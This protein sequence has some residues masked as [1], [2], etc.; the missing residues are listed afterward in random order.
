MPEYMTPPTFRI[1]R[2]VNNAALNYQ[3]TAFA[4]CSSMFSRV[5]GNRKQCYGILM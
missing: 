3:N 5:I 1:A 4:V 2:E